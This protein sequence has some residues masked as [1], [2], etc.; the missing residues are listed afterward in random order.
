MSSNRYL[1]LAD[2]IVA[3]AAQSAREDCEWEKDLDASALRA[4]EIRITSTKGYLNAH[5]AGIRQ[6][7]V[8]VPDEEDETTRTKSV[9][10]V[11]PKEAVP[12]I[13]SKTAKARDIYLAQQGQGE[14]GV[15][16]K[17]L[18]KPLLANDGLVSP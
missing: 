1:E 11:T 17:S 8:V 9:P 15:E 6:V 5:G 13:A 2:W 14:F 12:A 4:G 3:D 10:K 16:M 7:P 18:T